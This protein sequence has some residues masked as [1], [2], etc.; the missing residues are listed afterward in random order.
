M[1]QILEEI[2]F[3]VL[4]VETTG[5]Y[6]EKDRICEI[7]MAALKNLEV[8]NSFTSLVNPGVEIP[9]SVFKV[10]GIDN[11]MVARSPS[12]EEIANIVMDFI[13]ESVLVGHNIEFDFGFLKEEM[14]RAG[15]NI[16]DFLLIDTVVLSRKLYSIG[17]YKL[18]TVAKHLN[19]YSDTFHRAEKDVE[20]TVKIFQNIIRLLQDEY[21]IKSLREIFEFIKG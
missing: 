21:G 18:Q 3:V 7:S 9:Y 12:F 10:H 15:Y 16:G 5:F 6:P 19:I 11:D 8:V 14:Q 17:N 20:V 13:S 4:D 1:D 2:R